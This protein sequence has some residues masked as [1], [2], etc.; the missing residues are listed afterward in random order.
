MLSIS[1]IS[2]KQASRYYA[3][4]KG[5]YAR[6][7][8]DDR[9]QGKLREELGLPETLHPDDFDRL[10]R[11]RGEGKR[12]GYDL[13]FSAPKSVSIA[14][15][16]E[17]YQ[18]D[19]IAAHEVA[20]QATLQKIE[21]RE[22]GTRV[23]NQHG[24]HRV[25]TGNMICGKFRHYVSRNS[26]PQMH[27]H[28][29]VLN[30]TKYQDTFYSLEIRNLYRDKIM[31]G[32]VYR[33]TLAS[34]LLHRGYQLRVTDVEKG[35]FELDGVGQ[36]IIDQF[37]TRRQEIV[38]KL[39]EWGTTGGEAA[40]KA[41][42]LTRQAKTEKDLD[43]LRQSWCETI[44]DVGGVGIDKSSQPIV[45]DE[46]KMLSEF[47]QAIERLANQ[48][49]AFTDREMKRV[50]LASGVGS[51]LSEEQYEKLLQRYVA[52]KKL[53]PLRLRGEGE[54]HTTMYYSTPQNIETEREIF[55]GVTESQNTMPGMG[56]RQAEATLEQ[57]LSK[58]A[59]SLGDQQRQAVLHI[60]QV[61]DQYIA[62]QGLAGT[63][64]TYMLN[65]AREVLESDGYVVKGMSFTGKAAQGLELDARIP[66]TTIHAFLNRLEKEAGNVPKEQT[67]NIKTEWNL[68]GLKPGRQKEFWVIDEA[69]MLDNHLLSH[70]MDAAAAKQAKVVMV[71]DRQQLLP[72]GVGNAFGALVESQ[73]VSTVVVDEIIRQ[74]DSPEL[75]RAVREAVMGDLDTSIFALEK[76]TEVV[77]KRSV[78]I[79]A[80]VSDYVSLSRE[81]QG[82][83]IV[84]TA[85]NR[86][87]RELN[88]AIRKE[89]LQQGQ[90]ADGQSY[91]VADKDGKTQQQEFSIGDKVIFLRNDYKIGVRNGQT[92]VVREL[93]GD[94][95]RVLSNG[96]E[97]QIDVSR[98]NDIDYGY[99][100]TSHKAQG[101]TV[102]RA[103]IHL[104]SSQ[105]HLNSRNSY[106]VDVSRARMEVKIYTDNV[107]K[108][109]KQIEK[110]A[111]KLTLQDFM[112]K[113]T[114]KNINEIRKTSK[115]R[116]LH[117]ITT[118][119][120][121]KASMG[122]TMQR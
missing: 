38:E 63:G 11:E 30:K 16:L 76:Q 32:Q 67:I 99:V 82:K 49:F 105:Q 46:K 96:K 107:P 90:L 7:E 71:G 15:C 100:L 45:S 47:E 97:M 1:S 17:E 70:V 56:R 18:Q 116:H 79:K 33:N 85:G 103:I 27:T 101:V 121:K 75:L 72:V 37:S 83:T 114:P 51:G 88:Q 6:D 40:E 35:Y 110:F 84:L 62:V 108:I 112:E 102:D 41:T 64:K 60:A 111:Q 50:A 68:E 8:S 44:Q 59:V 106:Y 55:R 43:F 81:Q 21:E 74:K 28:C 86:D 98:Y 77:E 104:D 36:D 69:S 115:V 10:I 29:V 94:V 34:E 53:V 14:T 2:P 119:E 23:R 22:I 5:Y 26:D 120:L 12:A 54:G 87:R 31:Y 92:G 3:Q 19:M 80:I 73:T 122:M 113:T 66:S 13:S 58:D 48:S 78:R 52:E 20:V 25:H 39:R 65:Y 89:L 57:I 118:S 24:Q 61:K 91:A 117:E 42:L 4:E 93:E 109:K 9:W 95:M